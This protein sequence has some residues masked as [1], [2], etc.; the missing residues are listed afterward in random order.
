LQYFR[1]RKYCSLQEVRKTRA[2]KQLATGR[3]QTTRRDCS[4]KRDGICPCCKKH[5]ARPD[6]RFVKRQRLEKRMLFAFLDGT[7]DNH[8][9]AAERAIRPNVV[10]RKI[11]NGHRSE[12]GACTHKILM[13]VRETCRS[14]GQN[15]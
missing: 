12:S 5:H 8:N 6:M 2:G 9:N 3:K 15:W 13:S 14:R 4:N 11:T 7:T 1:T 10:I